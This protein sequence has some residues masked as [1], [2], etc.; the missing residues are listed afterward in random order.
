MTAL[1]FVPSRWFGIFHSII[2]S[3]NLDIVVKIMVVWNS[4]NFLKLSVHLP[5]FFIRFFV[6]A[7]I[8]YRTQQ[9][10]WREFN[11]YFTQ[12]CG[13]FYLWPTITISFWH[14][15]LSRCKVIWRFIHLMHLNYCYFCP[16]MHNV[17]VQIS[18]SVQNLLHS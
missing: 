2:D 8:Y 12:F 4:R 18:F 5:I 14:Q 3:R 9:T 6:W 16:T 1:T 10:P 11:F 13:P 17:F 15:T 7:I